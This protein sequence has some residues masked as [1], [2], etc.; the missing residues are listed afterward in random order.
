MKIDLMTKSLHAVALTL[1][2]I[3][4]GQTIAADYQSTV[5][6]FNPVG[7]WRL[8]ESTPV[9]GVPDVANNAGSLGGLG[10]GYP[11]PALIKAEAGI[12]G[13]AFRFSNPAAGAAYDPNSLIDVPQSA[14][15]NPNGPFTLEFWAN[16]TTV[17]ND[18]V[19][20]VSSLNANAS[21]SGYLIY[22]DAPNTRWEFRIGGT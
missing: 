4:A 10:R 14:A 11:G 19:C 15:L 2:A 8:G 12:V 6:S 9:P 13:T 5:M 7:Y 17:N 20:P 3:G 16:P 22:F 21:R 1:L 18:L